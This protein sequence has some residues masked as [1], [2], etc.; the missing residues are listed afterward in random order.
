MK[1][2]AYINTVFTLLKIKLNLKSTFI[3]NGGAS[4]K[5]Y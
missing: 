2:A 1:I 5:A 3:L 4:A